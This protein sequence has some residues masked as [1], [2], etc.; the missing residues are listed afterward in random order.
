MFH[1]AQAVFLVDSDFVPSENLLAELSSSKIQHR[2]SGA[3]EGREA[4][5]TSSPAPPAAIIVPCFELSPDASDKEQVGCN[6]FL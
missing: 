1:P 6:G 5:V 2:I 3:G 4:G